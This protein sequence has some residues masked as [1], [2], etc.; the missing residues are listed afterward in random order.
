MTAKIHKL[1][2]KIELISKTKCQLFENNIVSSLVM[3][4]QICDPTKK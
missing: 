4:F 3:T 1:K 2:L